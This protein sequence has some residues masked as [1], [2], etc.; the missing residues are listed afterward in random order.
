MTLKLKKKINSSTSEVSSYR[1]PCTYPR[2]HFF[3]NLNQQYGLFFLEYYLFSVAISFQMTC[4]VCHN[5]LLSQDMFPLPRTKIYFQ[6]PFHA[7]QLIKPCS[8][9]C[10]TYMTHLCHALTLSVIFTCKY[11]H[12]VTHP[13]KHIYLVLVMCLALS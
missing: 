1:V 10:V 6:V 9:L 7:T 5:Y 13:L 3:S 2:K 11:L 4:F 8:S 12:I